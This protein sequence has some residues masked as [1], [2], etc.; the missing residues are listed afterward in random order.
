MR[1]VAG[2]TFPVVSG[3]VL[4]FRFLKEIIMTVEADL[5]L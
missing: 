5:L 3:G 2:R 4:D 1:T